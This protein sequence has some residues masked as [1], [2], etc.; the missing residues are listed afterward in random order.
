MNQNHLSIGR[1]ANAALAASIMA[2][3][4]VPLYQ[5][6]APLSHGLITTANSSLFVQAHFSEPMTTYAL[7]WSDPAGYDAVSE[8]LAPSLMPSGEL[9]EHIEYPNAEAFL[10][11]GADDDLRAIGSDFKT[12][13]YTQTKT[14][15]QI[16]NRGLRIVLDW[17]RIKN[18]PNWQQHYT[19]MLMA[20]L[21]RNAFRR[22]YALGV[23]SATDAPLTWDSTTDPDYDVASQCKLSG[24]ASGISPNC[25]LW[26]Q[27]AK[28]LRFAAYGA[29]NQAKGLSGRLLSPE[30]AC[31]KIGLRGMVDESRYQ[32]G[33][34]KTSIVGAKVLLFSSYGTSGEDSSNFKT[35]RGVT[36]Q[37]G[38]FAVYVRQLS[39]KMWEI[40]VECYET[41][42]CA[43]TLGVRTLSIS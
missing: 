10:S 25:A 14:R 38:R 41:E 26:G 43:A 30:E 13:D 28:L 31:A 8:F 4:M 17:D 16:P 2:S 18:Q 34:S 37:G 7:G 42:F 6:D 39:V 3:A 20:R 23:A 15:R 33:T 36:Q 12:V 35:A 32:S 19:G 24:D 11:D 1:T 40:V 9:Y 22:K 29:T 21:A 27:Q 5:A